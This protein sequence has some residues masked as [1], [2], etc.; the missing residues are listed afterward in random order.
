M[1]FNS[2]F[3]LD[4]ATNKNLNVGR[5][6]AASFFLFNSAY[7]FTYTP[8]RGFLEY[9]LGIAAVA[10]YVA[11]SESLYPAECLENTARAKGVAMKIFV[12]SCTSFINLLCTP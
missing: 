7:A 5:A 10:Y 2:S 3:P 1:G 9:S 12:I 11:F 6:G 8:L 4:G